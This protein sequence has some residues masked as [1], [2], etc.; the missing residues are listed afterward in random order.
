M[1]KL[2]GGLA[3][4]LL[5]RFKKKNGDKKK[6]D[7][8][9]EA[10]EE[11]T[12]LQQL[13][14]DDKET[15]EALVGTMFLNPSKIETSMKDAADEAKKFEKAKDF[16]KAT[17]MY[18]IAGGLALYEGDVDKVVEYFS[19]CEKLSSDKKYPI[20]KNPEKAVAIAQAY[21]KNHPKA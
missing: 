12:E 5:D 7:A 4:G 17:T 16:V 11:V 15:Y 6:K 1:H 20:L 10:I 19:D 2:G 13:C 9:K 18:E 21:Y 8:A 14:G 3:L